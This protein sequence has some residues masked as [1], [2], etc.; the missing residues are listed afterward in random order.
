VG[1]VTC[2]RGL[3]NPRTLDAVLLRVI[4]AEGAPAGEARYRDL[5]EQYYGSG[6][7]DFSAQ[8]LAGLAGT[9]AQEHGDRDGARRLLLL[10]LEW[11]P[12]HADSYLLLAQLDLEA[13]DKAAAR[14][15][16][17]KALAIAPDHGFAKRLLRQLEQ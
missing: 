16:I 12:D 5:R 9:L 17:D 6:S 11:N 4:L 2:H 15:N 10:N 13:G 8:T 7:Y 14:A 1:C 3:E